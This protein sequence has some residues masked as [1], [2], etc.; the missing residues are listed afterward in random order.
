MRKSKNGRRI[1]RQG[2]KFIE[3]FIGRIRPSEMVIAYW[4]RRQ[5]VERAKA[6]MEQEEDMED[7]DVPHETAGGYD[8]PDD[9]DDGMDET[10]GAPQDME[11]VQEFD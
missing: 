3:E 11:Q 4:K 6:R 1:S 5:K 7:E 10:Y 8:V 9:Q 2:Q